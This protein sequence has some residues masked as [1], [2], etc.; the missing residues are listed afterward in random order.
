MITVAYRECTTASCSDITY[1]S[2]T[3]SY[4]NYGYNYSSTVFQGPFIYFDD[5]LT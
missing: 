4:I 3:V 2:G 1:D 5:A